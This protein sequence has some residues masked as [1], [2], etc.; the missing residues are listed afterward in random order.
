MRQIIFLLAMA[1]FLCCLSPAEAAV[2]IAV[3]PIQDISRGDE[4]VNWQLTDQF[5]RDFEAMGLD[6]VSRDTIISF[7][8]RHR[9]RALGSLDT[10]SIQRAQ[11]D[12]AVNLILLG[13]VCQQQPQPS[14]GLAVVASLI[15]TDDGQ[16]IWSNSVALSDVDTR[17]ILG[18]NEP[19]SL[20][21]LYPLL[22]KDIL[23]TWPSDITATAGKMQPVDLQSTWLRPTYIHSGQEVQCSVR[24]RMSWEPKNRPQVIFKVGDRVLKAE[25]S[26][27]E[28]F[29]DLTWREDGPEGRYPVTAVILWPDGKKETILLG[30]YFVDNQPPDLEL[31][32]KGFTLNDKT[33]FR[34]RLLIIPRLRVGEPLTQWRITFANSSGKTLLSQDGAGPPPEKLFWRGQ[35]EEGHSFPEGDYLITMKVWDRAGNMGESSKMVTVHLGAPKVKVTAKIVDKNLVIDL[36][37]EGQVPIAFWRLD[38]RVAATSAS[39]K[40]AEGTSMPTHVS[41]PLPAD[42]GN[43]AIVGK[44]IVQDILGN[45]TKLSIADI[46]ALTRP[47]TEEKEKD[48]ESGWVEEF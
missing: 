33:T 20:N 30:T 36:E 44:L 45:K 7:L 31:T 26:I 34:D 35:D 17:R 8:A 12:L 25:E 16:T 22:T 3:F 23:A 43:N 4:G 2:K 24:L 19:T 39:L 37:H 48:Q 1:L 47:K 10:Y 21:D 18:I 40:L 27:A 14:P 6:V 9:I 41:M 5:S 46:M 29:F 13:T 32:L 11:R 28:G 42:L 15:R 38:L